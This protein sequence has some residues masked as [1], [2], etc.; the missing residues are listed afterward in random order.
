MRLRKER[1]IITNNYLI[2]SKPPPS[3]HNKNSS[4]DIPPSAKEKNIYLNKI[5]QKNL[6]SQRITIDQANLREN[7][8]NFQSSIQSIL[9]NEESRQRAKNYVLNMRSKK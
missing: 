1:N 6:G 2:S 8:H 5:L 3:H 7:M 4:M 9:A